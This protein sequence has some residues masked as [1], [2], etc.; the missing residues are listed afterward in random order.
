MKNSGLIARCF[1]LKNNFA[2]PYF[3]VDLQS[4]SEGCLIKVLLLRRGGSL[5]TK[6]YASLAQLVERLTCNQ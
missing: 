2:Q 6:L 1:F 5:K 3:F 4:L